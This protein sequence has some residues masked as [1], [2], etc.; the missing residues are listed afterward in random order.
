M[1][2]VHDSERSRVN[3]K[4]SS[5]KSPPTVVSGR[6]L[7]LP[8]AEREQSLLAALGIAGRPGT[9]RAHFF[10]PAAADGDRPRSGGGA[11][12]HAS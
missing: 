7:A 6:I 1:F 9:N 3:E 2:G 10:N 4:D 8:P 5:T 11:K 12:L